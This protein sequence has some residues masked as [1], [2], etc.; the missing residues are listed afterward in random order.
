MP[1]ATYQRTKLTLCTCIHT[2]ILML[3]CCYCREQERSKFEQVIG[4]ALDRLYGLGHE[5]LATVNGL[6]ELL[7]RTAGDQKRV[8]PWLRGRAAR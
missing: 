5:E 1:L 2:L 4:T 6:T 8:P 3:L 7:N